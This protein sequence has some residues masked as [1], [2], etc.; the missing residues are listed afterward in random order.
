[1]DTFYQEYITYY[2][3]YKIICPLTDSGEDQ[4][5]TGT[6]QGKF[7]MDLANVIAIL[8]G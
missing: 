3:I 6:E 5:K 7:A 4:G 2:C 1:M 8:N